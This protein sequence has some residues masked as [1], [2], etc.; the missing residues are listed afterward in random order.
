MSF[1]SEPLLSYIEQM[2]EPEPEY[3][4]QIRREAH[5]R[6]VQPQ[7]L[8]GAYE[9]RLLTLITALANPLRVLEIGTY[10]GYSAL[11]LAE[12]LQ[13]KEALVHTLEQNDELEE[14]IQHNFSR[15]PYSKQIKLHIG[16]ALQL[17]P[18]LLQKET[19]DLVYLD[20][21]KRQYVD[22]YQL[23]L[24]FLPSGALIIADNTLWSGKILQNPM[25]LDA[26]TT[27]ID[28]FNRLVATDPRV[29]CSL[30]PVRD[31]ITLIRIK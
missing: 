24:P 29:Q 31:G 19:F 17:L 20:A 12:G 4:Y 27:G 23:I 16:N 8:V 9:G 1:L 2:S 6:L 10:C 5:L 30:L 18:S 25:P 11:C 21:D 28:A 3:L 22:Y 13:K 14:L 7:M 26:Q 15:S